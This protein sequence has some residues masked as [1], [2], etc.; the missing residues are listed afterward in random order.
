MILLSET[1]HWACCNIGTNRKRGY[2]HEVRGIHVDLTDSVAQLFQRHD[3]VSAPVIDNDNRLL[4][5]GTI[6]DVVDVIVEDA[7]THYWP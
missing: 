3:L 6:D 7:I 2:E 4:G 5:R 1:C